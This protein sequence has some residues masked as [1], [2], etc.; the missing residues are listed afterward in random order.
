MPT[1]PPPADAP[2]T[3]ADL[4][5]ERT[6]G[7][8]NMLGAALGFSLMGLGVKLASDTFPAMQLVFARSLVMTVVT[9]AALR[10]AGAPLLGVDRRTLALRG[11]VGAV[12][13]SFFY[14]GLG[15]LP[16]GDAVTIQYT[17]PVW[18]GLAAALLLGERLRPIVL[19]G[20]VLSLAGVVLVAKPSAL[21]GTEAALDGWGVAAV[22]GAAVLSGFAYTFVRKLR[23]TDRPMT[24]IFYLSWIG[25]LG[26]APFALSGAWVWPA[27]WDWLLLLGI[28]LATHAGQVGL[29]KGMAR[30]EAGTAASIGYLQ[31]VLAFGWGALVLH[32]LVDGLSLLG[33]TLVVS[34]VLLVVRRARSG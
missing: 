4:R 23:Q 33:A 19:L 24:I 5:R 2:P 1:S 7:V 31:V 10:H 6:W 30:L 12:A 16:L 17:T 8:A 34:S 18:T 28:G 13:L 27:G 29:T 26:A 22:A 15:R 14:V 3:E 20:T 21:F 11:G 9:V 25:L 32:E